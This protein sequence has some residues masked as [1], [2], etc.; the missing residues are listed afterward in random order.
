MVIFDAKSIVLILNVKIKYYLRPKFTFLGVDSRHFLD[1]KK[2]N[3]DQN[4]NKYE[5]RGSKS[6]IL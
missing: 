2:M 5:I 3:R 6:S 4:C 1:Q